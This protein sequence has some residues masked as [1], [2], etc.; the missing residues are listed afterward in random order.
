MDSKV[1]A[2]QML[3]TKSN[4]VLISWQFLK[5]FKLSNTSRFSLCREGIKKVAQEG[6]WAS[7]YSR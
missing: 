6:D 2:I 5:I 3:R 1:G 7:A 4:T